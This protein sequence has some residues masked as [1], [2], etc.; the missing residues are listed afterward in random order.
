ME[1][2][3]LKIKL[4]K[5]SNFKVTLVHIH[6]LSRPKTYSMGMTVISHL[7]PEGSKWKQYKHSFCN[8]KLLVTK[9]LLRVVK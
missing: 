2:I 7:K 4:A 9:F 3:H 5:E 6:I 8:C 1:K